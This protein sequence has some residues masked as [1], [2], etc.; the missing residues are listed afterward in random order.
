MYS[1]M[2]LT[3]TS[4]RLSGLISML[5][6]VCDDGGKFFLVGV[7]Y[8]AEFGL[9]AGVVGE[10]GQLAQLRQIGDPAF[11]DTAGDQ[12]RQPRVGLIQPQARGDA[13]GDVGQLARVVAVE[14]GKD[15]GFH[16]LGMDLRHAVDM[17]AADNREVGHAYAPAMGFVDDGHALKPF[18]VAGEAV[19]DVLQEAVIDFIDDL[20]MTRQHGLEQA[21]RPGF[22]RFR[23]QGVIGV[24][25]GA[26]GNVP[27]LIPVQTVDVHQQAHQ[28]R[29]GDGGVGVVELDRHLVRQRLEGIVMLADSGR[30]CPAARR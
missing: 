13:V 9:K 20:Q 21:H 11:A 24:G 19:H 29:N 14:I 4:N 12:L 3:C 23:H 6:L 18:G 28:F 8:G 1:W 17:V 22:Q 27:G 7:L 26:G 15:G 25:E 30:E 2:R 5:Q 10:R 16:Q